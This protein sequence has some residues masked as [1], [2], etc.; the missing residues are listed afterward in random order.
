VSASR[1]GEVAVPCS[2]RRQAGHS[3]IVSCL[4][5]RRRWERFK[6]PPSP[7]RVAVVVVVVVVVVFDYGDGEPEKSCRRRSGLCVSNEDH[8][9]C[10]SRARPILVRE[11]HELVWD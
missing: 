4:T 6:E 9:E 11:D 10:R 1:C 2:F 8:D 7:P 5:A 3:W